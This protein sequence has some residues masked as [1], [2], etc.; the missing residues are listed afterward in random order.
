MFENMET[1]TL[2]EVDGGG[3]IGPTIPHYF[4]SKLVAW[5]VSRI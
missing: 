1:R 3:V 2:M 4:V 5:I